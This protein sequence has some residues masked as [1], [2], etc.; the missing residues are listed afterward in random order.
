MSKT[1]TLRRTL[2]SAPYGSPELLDAIEAACDTL[3]DRQFA[4]A[5][6]KRAEFHKPDEKTARFEA[7]LRA[8]LKPL[9]EPKRARRAVPSETDKY[10]VPKEPDRRV[11]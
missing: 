3:T 1:T 2:V 10:T 8:K 6:R 5:M 11:A 9:D 4:A 7:R